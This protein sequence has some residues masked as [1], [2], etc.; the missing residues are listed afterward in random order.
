[1]LQ[2]CTRADV[3]KNKLALILLRFRVEIVAKP[4][5]Q[6]ENRLEGFFDF[7]TLESTHNVVLAWRENFTKTNKIQNCGSSL[8]TCSGKKSVNPVLTKKSKNVPYRKCTHQTCLCKKGYAVSAH[9]IT[10][11]GSCAHVS[12]HRPKAVSYTGRLP[13]KAWWS[14]SQC[15]KCVFIPIR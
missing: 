6:N 14:V 13:P 1:M 11:Q 10:N 2:E 5:P 3:I 8:C 4:G 15:A 9:Q 7:M 12:P